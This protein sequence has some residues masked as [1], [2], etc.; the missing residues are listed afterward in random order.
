MID[1]LLINNTDNTFT[2]T[3]SSA[4]VAITLNQKLDYESQ[5]FF[6]L[7]ISAHDR[8]SPT[9]SSS[10]T[11]EVHVLDVADSLPQ[12]NATSYST[13]LAEDAPPSTYLLTVHATSQDSAPLATLQYVKVSGDSGNHF[14]LDGNT[15]VITLT[16]SLDFESTQVHVLVVQAQSVANPLLH[17][18]T[19]VQ[20]SVINVNDH[21]PIF[22]RDLYTIAVLETVGVSHL[23]ISVDAPDLDEGEFGKVSYRF[24][25]ST[26]QVVLDTFMLDSESGQ[27]TTIASLDREER[28]QYSFIVVGID[29][30]APPRS[31]TSRVSITVTDV[32]DE[33]PVFTQRQ[34]SAS[35]SENL[36]AGRSVIQVLAEDSDSAV[37]V[38]NY[39]IQSGNINSA[40]AIDVL[41]GLISTRIRLDREEQASYNLLVVANDGSNENSTR[42]IVTVLDLNDESPTFDLS[43]YNFPHVSEDVA[44]GSQV[45]LVQA[46]DLDE[47]SNGM[48]VYTSTNIDRNFMIDRESGA[49]VLMASLDYE[50]TERYVFDVTA[51]DRGQPP[52][53]STATV[54]IRVMDVND[55]PPIFEP[56]PSTLNIVENE[57]AGAITTVTATDADSGQNA[58]IRYEIAGDSYARKAF[59]IRQNG[60]V[61]T[62]ESL[63]R[64]IISQYNLIIRAVDGGVVRQTATLSLTINVDDVIDYPPVFSEVVYEVLI[65]RVHSRGLPVVTVH[66]R[67]LDLVQPQSIIYHITSGANPSLFSIDQTTGMIFAETRID[68]IEHEGVYRLGIMAQHRH[69]SESVFAVIRVMVDDGIPRLRPLTLYFSGY[70]TLIGPINHLGV[71]EIQQPKEGQEYTFSLV[72]S[73]PRAQQHF[74]INPTTGYLS[75]SNGVSSGHYQ[76]NVSASTSTGNG[77][78]IV[79]VFVTILTNQTLENAVVATFGGVR[80]AS[81]AS[82]QLDQFIQFL[83]ET[84]PCSRSQVEIVG[85]QH[86]GQERDE[87]VSVAFAMRQPDMTSYIHRDSLLDVL[88]ANSGAVQPSTLLTFGSDVCVDEPCSNLQRCRPIVDVQR[89]SPATP[90][91]VIADTHHFHTFS[92]NF[93]CSCPSGYSREDLCSSEIDECDPSPCFFGAECIDLVGDYRC[94]CPAG[95][96]DKNCSSICAS[97]ES[98][99]P[100]DTN[101][102]LYEGT[103]I[104]SQQDLVSYRCEGCPWGNEFSG[105]NCELTSLHFTS[106]H[107]SFVA[108][109]TTYDTS[110]F[111]VNFRFATVSPNGLLFY[112]G[113]LGSQQDYVA[114]EL[115]IGQLRVGVSFGGVT[116]VLMTESLWNLNDGQ[117]RSVRIRLRNKVNTR[118]L[119]CE[120]MHGMI[121]KRAV[122]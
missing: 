68:P 31:S 18:Q 22:T 55:N 63:D 74:F 56:H 47:G 119:P 21:S 84:V 26:E 37:S 39:Y 101:P 67:T 94:E 42:V 51:T 81:F 34:Y 85:I 65:T 105:Q 19:N 8:G 78:T 73:D 5:R 114:A 62:V 116:T 1:F 106:K 99:D 25:E 104:R 98:C 38:V 120:S 43:L 88:K 49:I 3:E 96:Y 12:F 48:V 7:T 71:V 100:C 117:W 35:I 79:D 44:V 57:P 4:Q 9:R 13:E 102:C 50:E 14:S 91:R 24:R 10:A 32:N 29:G 75:V 122:F 45:G 95:T 112:A 61:Y 89:S 97:P 92:D 87:M 27:I 69:L 77:S 111:D 93:V 115:V 60:E 17:S 33:A 2:V 46:P 66:A 76:L 15:G 36:D 72:Y 82:I 16:K 107:S 90:F 108:F 113:N 53:S 70:P 83:T 11:L 28:E 54:Q 80:E 121:L 110:R 41:D 58:A 86:S 118:Q 40:F 59:G 20:I 30:G 6:L 109:Q 52:R 103:C 23:V 64:E